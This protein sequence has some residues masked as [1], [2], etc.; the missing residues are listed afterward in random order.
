MI[1]EIILTQQAS[2]GIFHSH[3]LLIKDFRV[4]VKTVRECLSFFEIPE[5]FMVDFLCG[6]HVF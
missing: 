5:K 1:Y 6:F 3:A 4:I 2:L